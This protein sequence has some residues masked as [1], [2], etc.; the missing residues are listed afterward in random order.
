MNFW[1]DLWD[2]SWGN[3]P[4]N[5]LARGSAS[6]AL[7]ACLAIELAVSRFY[8]I[9]AAGFWEEICEIVQTAT[10]RVDLLNGLEKALSNKVQFDCARLRPFHWEVLPRIIEGV[11][12]NRILMLKFLATAPA[13][14]F[15]GDFLGQIYQTW[16]SERTKNGR[17][18]YYTSEQLARNLIQALDLPKLKEYM[19]K[20]GT[21]KALICDP[22]CGSGIFFLELFRA[23][24]P[25]LE[26]QR[27]AQA[28]DIQGSDIDPIAVWICRLN[29]IIWKILQPIQTL[30]QIRQLDG[31]HDDAVPLKGYSFII[32]NPPFF[33]VPAAKYPELLN[34]FTTPRRVNISALFVL[35]YAPLL[36]D[37]GQLG[38]IFPRAFLFSDRWTFLRQF[39]AHE[40]YHIP[41]LILYN[42]GFARVGLEQI[43]LFVGRGV[44]PAT[45][46][47]Q[48][49]DDLQHD[50]GTTAWRLSGNDLLQPPQ[51]SLPLFATLDVRDILESVR[52]NSVPLGSLCD[53]IP[54]TFEPAIFRGLGWERLLSQNES[55]TAWRA[56]KGTDILPFGVKQYRYVENPMKKSDISGVP[57]RVR[58]ILQRPVIVCQ[59]LVSSKT[60]VVATQLPPE[61]VPISTLTCIC[62]PPKSPGISALI[63]SALNS[64]FASYYVADHVFLHSRLS[65]SLDKEYLRYFP[66]PSP[67]TLDPAKKGLI[68]ELAS[69]LE[70]IARETRKLFIQPREM[71][72]LDDLIFHY[73]GL[74]ER[75]GQI[76]T[77]KLQMFWDHH[78]L[79]SLPT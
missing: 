63:V 79:P 6:D 26:F 9:T 19:V 61:T 18:S 7:D 68:V 2:P 10:E 33:E 3:H 65:T 43:S 75:Q 4:P 53:V 16:E 76:L 74:S 57:S 14:V 38:F 27:T 60:R 62:L 40:G 49:F 13:Q 28:I 52:K 58:F 39:L 31:L 23:L 34:S 17:G 66:V 29:L 1:Q 78:P 47:V 11:N 73:Y 72:R 24:S 48:E 69:S 45:V 67:A 54:G 12:N 46:S 77:Q 8:S 70:G 71:Q 30:Q 21:K 56:I 20:G 50:N 59:R 22:A 35:K 37:G 44:A 41:H 25:T 5:S 36:Q 55:P 32:G 42:R 15:N 64:T 51:Y